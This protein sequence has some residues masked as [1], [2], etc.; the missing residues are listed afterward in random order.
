[1]SPRK[2]IGLIFIGA[3]AFGVLA[4]WAK[5]PDTDGIGALS[6]VRADVGN[7]STPWLLVAFVAGS[8]AARPWKGAIL[9]LATT[10]VALLGFYLLTSMFINVGGLDFPRNIPRELFVNRVY[11]EGGLISGAV[12]GALGAWWS[13]RRSVNASILVGGLLMLEPLILAAIGR[14]TSGVLDSPS[15][16]LFVRI[17]PAFGLSGDRPAIQTGVYLAEFVVGLAILMV[18]IRRARADRITQPSG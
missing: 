2:R 6:Q 18:G 15:I 9:G 5:G 11:L 7:L 1:M 12:F 17:V 4:A 8:F 16:P 3:F 10:M 13:R 14:F